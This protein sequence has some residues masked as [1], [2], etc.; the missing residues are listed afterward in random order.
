[1][2]QYRYRGHPRGKAKTEV[3]KPEVTKTGE[4]WSESRITAMVDATTASA[5]V[6][7]SDGRG[8]NSSKAADSNESTIA[9]GNE[10]L[11]PSW[12]LAEEATKKRQALQRVAELEAKVQELERII[13]AGRLT[14]ARKLAPVTSAL[15]KLG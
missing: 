14:E 2:R 13:K 8:N 3:S 10:R 4:W 1:L 9:F 12:R 6:K 5:G 11:V 15:P 7:T